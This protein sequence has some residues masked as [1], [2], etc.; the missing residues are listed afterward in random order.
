M[1]I[2]RWT[3]ICTDPYHHSKMEP[4]ITYQSAITGNTYEAVYSEKGYKRYDIFLDGNWVQ[5]ALDVRD[6]PESVRDYEQ[7]GW[8][9][10]TT[11]PRD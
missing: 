9:G 3:I 6:I 2:A 5:F 1:V 11:S 8:H 7:P 4:T 10:V